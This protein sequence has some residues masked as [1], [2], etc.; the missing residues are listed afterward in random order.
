MADELT[1]RFKS[2]LEAMTSA[3]EEV[4]QWLTERG[5]SDAVQY[6][7]NL[8]IEE[9]ATNCIKFGY[10]DANEHMLEVRL[11]VSEQGV[12]LTFVDDG[13]PFN[14]LL[15]GEPDLNI[16]AE[17]RSVGGLGIHLLR[18]MSDRMEYVRKGNQNVVILSKALKGP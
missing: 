3:S 8:A 5:I 17:E 1:V 7:A 6:L 11:A 10:D 14:P 9:L 4:S 2:T 15:R 13:R 16:P 12:V 18:R